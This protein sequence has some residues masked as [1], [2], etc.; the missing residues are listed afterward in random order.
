MC[1]CVCDICMCR[2]SLSPE[3]ARWTFYS[4]LCGTQTH[5]H[6]LDRSAEKRFF[7]AWT[8]IPHSP[9][10][11]TLKNPPQLACCPVLAHRLDSWCGPVRHQHAARIFLRLLERVKSTILRRKKF[12]STSIGLLV[13]DMIA[14]SQLSVLHIVVRHLPNCAMLLATELLHV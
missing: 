14:F 2:C 3:L 11:C 9:N 7:A 1:V 5:H 6:T 13:S 10:A 4:S 12:I 8:T